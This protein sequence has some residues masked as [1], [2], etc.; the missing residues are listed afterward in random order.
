MIRRARAISPRRRYAFAAVIRKLKIKS[1]NDKVKLAEAKE[2]TYMK[3]FYEGVMLVGPHAG[4]YLQQDIR[5]IVEYAADRG[6]RVVPEVDLPAHARGLVPLA[7]AAGADFSATLAA[8]GWSQF[9]VCILTPTTRR[10]AQAA[11]G[12]RVT[13]TAVS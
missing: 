13:R 8:C 12:S 4:H 2:L 10:R 1:M 3:G 6:I 9:L 11:L 7:K 5:D